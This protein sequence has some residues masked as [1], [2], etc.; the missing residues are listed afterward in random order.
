MVQIAGVRYSDRIAH[1][2]L[3][4][5]HFSVPTGPA[6]PSPESITE[7]THVSHTSK[8]RA[9]ALA[10]KWSTVLATFLN[11]L[12]GCS[13]CLGQSSNCSQL[14]MM[15]VKLESADVALN[16]GL[17]KLHMIDLE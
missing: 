3:G 13:I 15:S 11:L 5:Y 12:L 9:N 6:N 1:P 16:S 10:M 14:N 4:R 7:A 17:F 2:F 8:V